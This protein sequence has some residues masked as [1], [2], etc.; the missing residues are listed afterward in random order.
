MARPENHSRL[1][2]VLTFLDTLT[3]EFGDTLHMILLEKLLLLSS[4]KGDAK[5]KLRIG[6]A[7]EENP[8][9]PRIEVRSGTPVTTRVSAFR[10]A[11]K[12]WRTPQAY[13]NPKSR[14][15]VFLKMCVATC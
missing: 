1:I 3:G 12:I 15:F 7:F 5:Q 11:P 14:N 9:L 13:S 8:K 4:G 6:H 10:S 2:Q